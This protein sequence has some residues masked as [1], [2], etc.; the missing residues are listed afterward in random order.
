MRKKGNALISAVVG[1]AVVGLVGFT[2]V[3]RTMEGKKVERIYR[4]K[5]AIAEQ[6]KAIRRALLNGGS[7]LACPAPGPSVPP[8]PNYSATTCEGVIDQNIPALKARSIF[9]CPSS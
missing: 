1:A 3:K 4:V 7:Y 8:G 5:S 9:G 2:V 6:E